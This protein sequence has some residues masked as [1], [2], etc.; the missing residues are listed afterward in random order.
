MACADALFLFNRSDLHR[1]YTL[2]DFHAFAIEPIIC[3]SC[4]FLHRGH[5]PVGFVSWAWLTP[6]ES[7]Q[8]LDET[9]SLD[10]AHYT[11]K[12]APEY[13]LWGIEF[14]AP[15]GDARHLMRQARDHAY[16]VLGMH[17][18]VNFRRLRQ[19]AKP[20]KIGKF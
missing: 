8:F 1:H 16:E 15:F 10:M 14:I 20:H 19:P 17:P 12:Q 7:Q 9:L 4:L 18:K 6:Q 3:K 2:A 5:I 11:R 13:E